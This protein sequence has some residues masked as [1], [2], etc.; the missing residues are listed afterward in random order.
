MPR[1][2]LGYRFSDHSVTPQACGWCTLTGRS[3]CTVT[4]LPVGRVVV[5]QVN[6]WPDVVDTAA[7]RLMGDTQT[8]YIY[9]IYHK[10][11]AVMAQFGQVLNSSHP[12]RANF[13]LY[14]IIEARNRLTLILPTWKIWWS[15]NSSSWHMGFNSEFKGLKVSNFNLLASKFYI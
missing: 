15:N 4:S 3:T 11:S 5:W 1:T 6:D 10:R 14:V 7:V 2:E 8:K 9:W 13:A 12:K